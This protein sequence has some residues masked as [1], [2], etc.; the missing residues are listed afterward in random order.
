[1][2]P[3]VLWSVQAFFYLD[4]SISISPLVVSWGFIA[5]PVLL[6][7]AITA[8]TM[9]LV[10]RRFTLLGPHEQ[11]PQR[12]LMVDR[13]LE[14]VGTLRS[15]YEEQIRLAARQE[16]RARLARD[17]HD[18]VKQQLFVIQTAA[19]TVEAR[20][21][22]DAQGAKDAAGQIRTAAREAVVEMQALIEQLQATPMENVGLVDALKKQCEALGFRTGADVNLEIGELP[23]SASLLPGSQLALFRAAQE[24]LANIGRH[25]RARHVA[26]KLGTAGD[27]LELFIRDDGVGFEPGEARGGMGLRNMTARA[28]E[29]GGSFTLHSSPGAGTSI[30]I[31][32]PCYPSSPTEYG[33]KALAWAAFLAVSA[34]YWMLTDRGPYPW[35]I[36]WAGIVGIIVAR[37]AVAYFRLRGRAV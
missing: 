29:M 16:E 31:S 36:A 37:Y 33:R 25:A 4:H 10:R 23:P 26:V 22:S 24:A 13:K 6:Y 5:G 34:A 12:G 20:L 19:A 2:A 18:A 21:D 3:A 14:P 8:P 15:A 9:I 30:Q 35:H 27:R 1:L 28:G 11:S 32:V 7:A 17:L